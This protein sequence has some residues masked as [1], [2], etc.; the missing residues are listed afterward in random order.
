MWASGNGLQLIFSLD[1]RLGAWLGFQVLLTLVSFFTF[2][3]LVI[4]ECI[5]SSG[6][7][8]CFRPK[9]HTALWPFETGMNTWIA[10]AWT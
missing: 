4:R 2:P 9:A 1:Y 7:L 3:N 5:K 6:L 10:Y 8:I